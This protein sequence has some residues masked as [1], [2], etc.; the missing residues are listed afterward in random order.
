MV[1]LMEVMP[2]FCFAGF[3]VWLGWMFFLMFACAISQ[4]ASDRQAYFETEYFHR[5]RQYSDDELLAPNFPDPRMSETEH[6][7]ARHHFYREQ[8]A[9]QKRRKA[10]VPYRDGWVG[11]LWDL[12]MGSD[13]KDGEDVRRN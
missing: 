2:I 8:A 4:S 6:R 12:W 13:M 5:R 7:P 1:V 3:A 10:V 9:E 11:V